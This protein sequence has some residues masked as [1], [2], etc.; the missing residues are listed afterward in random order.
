MMTLNIFFFFQD[1]D[2]FFTERQKTKRGKEGIKTHKEIVLNFLYKDLTRHF[3]SCFFFIIIIIPYLKYVYLYVHIDSSHTLY[4][5]ISDNTTVI[6]I[7]YITIRREH[8]NNIFFSFFY[9]V[10][11]S[12]FVYKLV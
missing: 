8:T 3:S 6:R 4:V 1:Q 10:K 9:D 12:L 7:G 5:Y 11:N 2:N